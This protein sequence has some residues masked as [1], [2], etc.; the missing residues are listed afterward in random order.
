MMHITP[1][2]SA[3]THKAR[4]Y[5]DSIPAQSYIAIYM[6]LYVA[7]V[8]PIVIIGIFEMALVQPWWKAIHIVVRA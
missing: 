5:Y 8:Q 3:E 6:Y 2:L 7:L 4:E 1:L